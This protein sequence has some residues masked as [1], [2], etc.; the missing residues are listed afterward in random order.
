MYAFVADSTR[1]VEGS[2][3]NA[4]NGM[5]ICRVGDEQIFH[6][7][8]IPFKQLERNIGLGNILLQEV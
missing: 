5:P 2:I 3:P 6:I 8:T 7:K 4:P 1:E